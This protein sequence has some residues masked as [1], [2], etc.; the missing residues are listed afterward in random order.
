MCVSDWRVCGCVVLFCLD[1]LRTNTNT[2]SIQP[3]FY[4]CIIILCF[5]FSRSIH[6]GTSCATDG[7]EHYWDQATMGFMDVWT[8]PNGAYYQGAPSGQATGAYT[9][10]N[11]FGAEENRGRAVIVHGSDG[12]R[13]GCGLLN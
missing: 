13:I 1:S 10:Y 2:K 8:V 5:V 4:S 9:L 11:G 7:G 3:I 6:D 12:S